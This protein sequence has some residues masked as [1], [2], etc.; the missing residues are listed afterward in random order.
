[1][2]YEV[3]SRCERINVVGTSGS[4]KSTFGR[5]LAEI[6]G[7]PFY[8]I[9]QLFWKP[10]WQE[11]ADEELLAKIQ[12]VCSQPRWILDGNYTRTIPTKWQHVQCVV[13]LD[14]SLVRTVWRVTKRALSRCLS[15]KELWPGTGNR[16]TIRKVFFSKDSII[17]WAITSYG[18]NRKNYTAMMASPDYSHIRFLRLRSP[19][20]IA[21]CL[22]EMR[23]M[24]TTL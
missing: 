3:I 2:D 14:L 20:S 16:E 6:L 24:R 21:A 15:K 12:A 1:M 22:E 5:E 17:W 11:T 13:W 23:Q 4:G 9:D 10:D 8:E 18:T 19:K 7:L